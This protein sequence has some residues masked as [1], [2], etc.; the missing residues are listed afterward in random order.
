M[1]FFLS[2]LS[3]MSADWK[4]KCWFTINNRCFIYDSNIYFGALIWFFAPSPA[5]TYEIEHLPF[6]IE[7]VSQFQN[8][9][10][11][12]YQS[13]ETQIWYYITFCGALNLGLMS[14]LSIVLA[15]VIDTEHSSISRDI[16]LCS[17]S[18]TFRNL[19]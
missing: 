14:I 6:S 9:L 3:W 18:I 12:L 16:L 17:V 19:M 1:H 11:I 5:S 13:G 15:V 7:D 8:H 4:N 10:V 2:Y